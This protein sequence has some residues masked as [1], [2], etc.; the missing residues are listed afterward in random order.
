MELGGSWLFP[1]NTE[2]E[3]EY[4]VSFTHTTSLEH[5]RSFENEGTKI[6]ML[7]TIK[8]Q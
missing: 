3:V 8:Y 2:R 4:E 5:N 6:K 7:E 1:H